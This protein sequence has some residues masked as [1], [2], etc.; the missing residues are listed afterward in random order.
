MLLYFDT[1]A[2]S[3]MVMMGKGMI[4][5]F[6]DRSYYCSHSTESC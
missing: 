2:S 1:T 3:R 6:S 4:L 5:S